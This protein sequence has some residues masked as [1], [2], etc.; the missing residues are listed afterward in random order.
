MQ[1]FPLILPRS[2]LRPVPVHSHTP[3]LVLMKYQR[4]FGPGKHVPSWLACETFLQPHMLCLL[5]TLSHVLAWPGP[6]SLTDT[7]G[8][9]QTTQ[10]EKVAETPRSS[11]LLA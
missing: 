3:P 11:H 6:E 7:C 1:Y 10:G 8:S 9:Y 5:I 4:H 2:A